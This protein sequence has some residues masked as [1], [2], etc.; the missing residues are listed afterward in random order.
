MKDIKFNTMDFNYQ[1]YHEFGER[2]TLPYGIKAMLEQIK[3]DE[4]GIG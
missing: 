1:Q 2:L 3:N 4:V